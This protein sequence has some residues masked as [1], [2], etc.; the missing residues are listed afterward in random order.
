[1]ELLTSITFAGIIGILTVTF[2]VL[3][4]I[5]GFPDQ[6]IKNYKRKSTQGLSTKLIFLSAIGY[7]LWTV[8]GFLR[9]D[10]V[11]VVGQGLGIITTGAILGQIIYYRK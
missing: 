10:W 2:G 6:I 3:V 8:H 11:L 1:M 4:K 5:I 7:I 9:N